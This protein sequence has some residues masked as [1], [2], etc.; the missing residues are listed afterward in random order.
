M[1][2]GSGSRGRRLGAADECRSR[3]SARSTQLIATWLDR[4][5]APST[6]RARRARL[7][8]ASQLRVVRSTRGAR[9]R[10]RPHVVAALE[11]LGDTRSAARRRKHP[12]SLPDPLDRPAA[13]PTPR[14]L[15]R[16]GLTPAC[17]ALGAGDGARPGSHDPAHGRR[18][19]A[20]ARVAALVVAAPVV[21]ARLATSASRA[22]TPLSSRR[23]RMS[24]VIASTSATARS[25]RATSPP[26]A[27]RSCWT[28]SW[29]CR[30]RSRRERPRPLCCLALVRADD[31]VA[32]G[33]AGS[34]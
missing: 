17:A 28:T 8:Q 10:P 14:L 26:R 7:T 1:Q 33:H 25:W 15:P 4:S 11:R 18:D 3:C 21:P 20:P 12:R 30:S 34:P 27:L 24:C 2:R 5:G 32:R 19:C 31:R 23:C 16:T 29:P 22:A 6:A 9:S 13:S